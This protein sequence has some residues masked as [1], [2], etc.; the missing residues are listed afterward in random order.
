M[1]RNFY[2]TLRTQDIGLGSDH[3][4]RRLINGVIM[5]GEQYLKPSRRRESTSYYG[6]DSGV[7]IAIKHIHPKTHRVGVIG[8]GAGAL[9]LWGQPGDTYRFY[10]ID[11]HVIEIARTEFSFL[12]NS[13]AMIETSLGDARLSLER[14]ASQNFDVLVVD[15]FS[16]DAIPVHLITKEA[17]AVYLK[18]VMPGGAVVFHVTNRFLKLAPVVRQIADS[19]GLYA[20][21]ITDNATVNDLSK[22]DWVIVTREKALVQA[23][24]I[25]GKSSAIE[26]IP[27]LQAWSDDFNNLFE[28]LK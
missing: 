12:E 26:D 25:A 24:P 19:L 8:L 7:V 11:P 6:P 1:V 5:H 4:K 13:E 27:G 20:T 17:M 2:G 23:E 18:H 16:S 22:S 9:A 21:L 3:A 14:E 15:A 28:I 10:D